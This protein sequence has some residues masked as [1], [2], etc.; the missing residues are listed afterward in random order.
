M[1]WIVLFGLLLLAAIFV[2]VPL[3]GEVDKND[4][5]ELK[6]IKS[7]ISAI[8]AEAGTTQQET[9]LESPAILELEARALE[10]IAPKSTFPKR[11][12]WMFWLLPAFLIAGTV[13][14]Y[15]TIGSPNFKYSNASTA[16]R[17]A[18]LSDEIPLDVLAERLEKRLRDDPDPP[19]IGYQ[20]LGRSLMGLGRYA[21][22]FSAYETAIE[23]SGDGVEIRSEYERAKNYV[24]SPNGPELSAETVDAF[25]QLSEDERAEMIA[26][27]VDGLALRLS[28]DP[29]DI[30]GWQRLLQSRMV[31]G[32]IEL[33]NEELRAG[34][35]A[36]S[37]RPELQSK[38]QSTAEALGYATQK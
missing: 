25:S 15:A 17:E 19:A 18:Q 16:E 36:L 30:E 7:Q 35:V 28:E 9:N 5:R 10:I 38:L 13:F 24:N 14:L 8:S 20:L 4:R 22:A 6:R 23:L 1:T 3:L 31:L 11:A 32:Q 2:M 21:D 33:G 12:N 27:M 37:S 29:T 34:L 26:G